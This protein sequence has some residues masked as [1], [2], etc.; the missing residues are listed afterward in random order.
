MKTQRLCAAAAVASLT[1]ITGCGGSDIATPSPATPTPTATTSTT[2]PSATPSTSSTPA[3]GRLTPIPTSPAA[4]GTN[5]VPSDLGELPD[6]FALPHEFDKATDEATAWEPTPWYTSCLDKAL[7]IQALDD[8]SA[9]RVRHQ[10]IP[11]GT[12]GEGVFEFAT[13]TDAAAFMTQLRDGYATCSDAGAVDDGYRTRMAS[14]TVSGPGE[15]SFAIRTW[16]EHTT[17]GS[18]W[19]EAP[20]GSLDLLTRQGPYVA[21]TYLGGEIVGDPVDMVTPEDPLAVT[22]GEILAAL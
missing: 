16:T 17:N 15:E 11:E 19:T 7:V 14:G 20:G 22:A 10:L 8:L 12:N 3:T 9:A 13:D 4:G 6:G 18:T 5:E 2:T 21:L 1:L